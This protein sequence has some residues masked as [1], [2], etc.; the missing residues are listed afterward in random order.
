MAEDFDSGPA[1]SKVNNESTPWSIAELGNTLKDWIERLGWLW[2]EGE[3]AQIQVRGGAQMFG[4]LRDLNSETSVQIH[5]WS[6]AGIDTDV[7]QG[8]RVVALIKPK[9]WGKG[10]RLQHQV[11]QMRK[12]GLGEML[13]RIEKLKQQLIAEGLTAAERKQPLPFLPGKIGLITGKD[14]DAEKDVLQNSL[15]RWPEAQ[16]RVIH[17]KVQGNVA[18]DEIIAA[19]KELDA[20]P[21]VDVIVVARGGGAF[22]DLVVFSDEKLVRAAAATNKPL[23]SAIGHENDSPLLDLVADVRASTPTD[24][25][26]RVVPDVVQERA[27][28]TGALN[29]MRSRLSQLI[30]GQSQLIAN[31]RSRPMLANPYG[32]I[33]T[34]QEQLA[35]LS[36]RLRT[37]FGQQLELAEQSLEHLRQQVRA[38]SPQSTLDRGYAVVQT[39]S[40]EVVR[41]AKTLAPNEKIKIRVAQGTIAA[42]VETTSSE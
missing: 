3:L 19:I 24:A 21:T 10:G 22:T 2:V 36:A 27:G 35:Q 1:V 18:A 16:F 6:M 41:E 33:D 7:R 11:A 42:N 17:T 9:F 37:R 23:V 30:D 25:A 26:K 34:H 32:F 38:L 5:S 15:R 20:D 40:G 14:S 29:N 13:E 31:A 4:E 12:V 39:Q 8:D 28:L